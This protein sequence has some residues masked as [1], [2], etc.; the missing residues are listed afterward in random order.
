MCIR[1]SR[2]YIVVY[3]CIYKIKF[4]S[5]V[6]RINRTPDRTPDLFCSYRF[7]PD[8]ALRNCSL[9]HLNN[10]PIL[11]RQSRYEVN[12]EIVSFTSSDSLS[13]LTHASQFKK[14]SHLVKKIMICLYSRDT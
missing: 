12:Y 3:C 5:Y 1:D 2:L 8:G 6:H 4:G 9:K 10:G 13:V 11:L 7:L 14:F